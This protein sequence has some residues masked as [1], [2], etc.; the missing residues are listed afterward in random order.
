LAKQLDPPF[1]PEKSQITKMIENQ[2]PVTLQDTYVSKAK[3]K[4]VELNK[5]AF[6]DFDSKN[7]R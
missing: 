1:L 2:N 3:V 6:E 4:K 7:K 5:S